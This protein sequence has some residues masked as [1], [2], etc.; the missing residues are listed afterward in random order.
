MIERRH[1][2][3]RVQ[4]HHAVVVVGRHEQHRRVLSRRRQRLQIVQ[5]R[6]AAM[7]LFYAKPKPKP[8]LRAYPKPKPKITVP[9]ERAELGLIVD[10]AVLGHPG[11]ADRE[12]LEAQQV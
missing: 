5:R 6:V 9:V 11:E 1:I 2:L 4:R 7:H 10:V 3:E 12:Q 8:K